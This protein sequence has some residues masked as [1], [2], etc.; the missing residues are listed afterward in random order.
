MGLVVN[1]ICLDVGVP[2]GKLSNMCQTTNS[3]RGT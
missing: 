1:K 2:L 3:V